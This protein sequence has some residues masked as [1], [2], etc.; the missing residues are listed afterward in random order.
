MTDICKSLHF[1]RR[2]ELCSHSFPKL[3][4]DRIVSFHHQ[5]TMNLYFH[6]TLAS[7]LTLSAD[8]KTINRCNSDGSGI[9]YL[10]KMLCIDETMRFKVEDIDPEFEGSDS[11]SLKLGITTCDTDIVTNFPF[12]VIE[13][14]QPAHDCMGNTMVIKIKNVNLDDEI[15][16]KRKAKG[17]IKVLVDDETQF[18]LSDPNDSLF[19]FSEKHVYP[20]VIL[21]GHVSQ[22]Q[23]VD[24]PQGGTGT[25]ANISHVN[26]PDICC[27]ICMDKQISHMA[28]PC[29]H[30]VYCEDHAN[31]DL[32]TS[33]PLCNKSISSFVRIFLP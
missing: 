16:L 20:F 8:Q 29:N 27:I 15:R 17:V 14:C 1:F 7:N 13:P 26:I 23:V 24:W 9:A 32:C 10:S 6:E 25:N 30:A 31:R 19:P 28:L 21:C 33:C 18:S 3:A 2:I 4:A 5:P 12:H 22:I 11:V